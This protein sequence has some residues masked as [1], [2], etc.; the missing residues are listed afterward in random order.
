MK[1]QFIEI[2]RLKFIT[3]GVILSG[4]T[5]TLFGCL[6]GEE[7]NVSLPPVSV[8]ECVQSSDVPSITSEGDITLSII[9]D[10]ITE[11]A[12]KSFVD[13][14]QN[15]KDGYKLLPVFQL[16]VDGLKGVKIS[17]ASVSGDVDSSL[18][19]VSFRLED[20]TILSINKHLDTVNDT[21]V[22]FNVIR[23]RVLIISDYRDINDLANFI[24]KAQSRLS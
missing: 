21:H 8:V 14:C 24:C 23:N 12:Q 17:K 16:I 4:I 9:D 11:K 5:F 15:N 22:A 19:N 13:F 6:S 7:E 2:A 1:K 20:G 18:L 3:A 10:T